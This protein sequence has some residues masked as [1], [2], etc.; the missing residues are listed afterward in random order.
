MSQLINSSL[1]FG[2][3]CVKAGQQFKHIL[4]MK[5]LTLFLGALTFC[6][7]VFG[8]VPNGDFE[9]W[10][11]TTSP[12][13]WQTSNGTGAPTAQ[14]TAYSPGH[15]SDHAAQ[16]VPYFD[17]NM[18]P[19]LLMNEFGIS[20]SP[21]S[22]EYYLKGSVATGDTL[23]CLASFLDANG[24][25]VGIGMSLITDFSSNVFESQT[26]DI[27]YFG[28]GTPT[29]VSLYFMLVTHS[30]NS[31]SAAIVDDLNIE[32]AISA[33]TS[34]VSTAWANFSNNANQITYSLAEP[35]T[36][37]GTIRLFDMSGKMLY[38]EQIARGS[39]NGQIN[40]NSLA[41]GM[42]IATLNCGAKSLSRKF[43]K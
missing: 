22:A 15:N 11:S 2:I 43:N 26:F 37:A 38:S 34:E 3:V 8:Q 35:T 25:I 36:A 4:S 29:V 40:I 6:V 17:G 39:M 42:Y 1:T 20:G 16:L 13:L 9:T 10:T 23:A 5:K 7:G 28:A 14:I 31:T 12:S 18:Y 21:T 41:T 33:S 32:G 24:D 27:A 19:A 30:L